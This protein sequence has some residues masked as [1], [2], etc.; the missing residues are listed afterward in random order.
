MHASRLLEIGIL[1]Y[2]TKQAMDSSTSTP[3]APEGAHEKFKAGSDVGPL[4]TTSDPERQPVDDISFLNIDSVD[5]LRHVQQGVLAEQQLRV[6][7]NDKIA[8]ENATSVAYGQFDALIGKYLDEHGITG[9]HPNRAQYEAFLREYSIDRVS[10]SDYNFKYEASREGEDIKT[11][12]EQAQ[13]AYVVFEQEAHKSGEDDKGKDKDEPRKIPLSDE[14]RKKL[15]DKKDQLRQDRDIV[16]HAMTAARE[17]LAAETARRQGRLYSKDET[18]E[19]AEH[20]RDKHNKLLVELGKLE[21][22][23]RELD[24]PDRSEGTKRL[25]VALWLL[26]QEKDLRTKI[27]EKFED[28]KVRSFIRWMNAGS[29]GRRILKGVAA[30]SVGAA[31]GLVGAALVSTGVGAMAAGVVAGAGTK[32]IANMFKGYAIAEGGKSALEINAANAKDAEAL[33]NELDPDRKPEYGEALIEAII[34]KHNEALESDTK[35]EQSK[36]RRSLGKAAVIAVL[37]GAAGM[38]AGMAWHAVFDGAGTGPGLASSPHQETIP[39]SPSAPDLPAPKLSPEALTFKPDVY[40][41]QSGEGWY[42]EFQNMDIPQDQWAG[43]LE[44]VG[45]QLH[46]IQT[47]SNGPLAYFDDVHKE[48]RLHMTPDGKMPQQAV[49]IIAKEAGLKPPTSLPSVPHDV[50]GQSGGGGADHAVGHGQT[51]DAHGSRAYSGHEHNFDSGGHASV[52]QAATPGGGAD[53]FQPADILHNPQLA[54]VSQIRQGE[55]GIEF[56]RRLGLK[57]QEWYRLQ[58]KV[59]LFK[60]PYKGYFIRLPNGDV[61][62]ARPGKLPME[63]MSNLLKRLPLKR[64][65][66]DL[67]A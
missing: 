36:R 26:E 44:K 27:V 40:S 2:I 56:V 58:D 39:A 12:R 60:G 51:V 43:L 53:S 24:T 4:H 38:G 29:R 18:K 15:E 3:G 59:D 52:D 19:Q 5:H 45:P 16:F 7:P 17:E 30:G 10:N 9:D 35:S 11:P 46:D 55:G 42:Q 14:E 8:I 20:L 61:G 64:S 54:D 32:L 22:Q 21:D 62:F 37:S 66:F 48:W 34:K 65:D 57:P 50:A 6:D 33:V 67:T 23:L 13:D 49:D 63:V 31:F 1:L 25:D 41:I 28:T 47:G